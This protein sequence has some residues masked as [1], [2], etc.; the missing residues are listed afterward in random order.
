M[1]LIYL[2]FILY[3]DYRG[4]LIGSNNVT[5]RTPA[6]PVLNIDDNIFVPVFLHKSE[7]LILNLTFEVLAKLKSRREFL[8]PCLCEEE[9]CSR[10]L[11]SEKAGSVGKASLMNQYPVH[12]GYCDCLE[13]IC[14]IFVC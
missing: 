7:E 10:L 8:S 5:T 12:T 2:C 6:S 11:F 3:S 13:L 14:V 1:I 9:L 4:V